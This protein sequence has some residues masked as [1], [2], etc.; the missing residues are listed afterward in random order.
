MDVS[1]TMPDK[2]DEV[3]SGLLDI[4]VDTSEASPCARC[5]PPCFTCI[6]MFNLHSNPVRQLQGYVMLDCSGNST[7]M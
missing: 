2:P 7:E 3:K 5:H 6:N 4:L 1:G